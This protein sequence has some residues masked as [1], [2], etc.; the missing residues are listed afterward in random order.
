[1]VKIGDNVKWDAGSKGML[2]GKVTGGEKGKRW[3]I[4]KAGKTYYVVKDKVKKGVV[5]KSEKKVVKKPAPA[6]AAKKPAP[7]KPAAKN[8]F[9]ARMVVVKVRNYGRGINKSDL[10]G[11]RQLSQKEISGT[12][13]K[14]QPGNIGNEYYLK[15]VKSESDKNKLKELS[16]G[17][18]NEISFFS[19]SSLN[20]KLGAMGIRDISHSSIRSGDSKQWYQ[21]P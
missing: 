10:N 21:H 14:K 12:K 18:P 4:E 11:F 20:K 16:M 7:K 5:K 6:P 15:E 13:A 17:Y 1:M 8:P 2:G 9:P 19:I 3:K